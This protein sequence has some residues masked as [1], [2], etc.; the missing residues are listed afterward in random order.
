MLFAFCSW[1]LTAHLMSSTSEHKIESGEE[2][3]LTTDESPVTVTVCSYYFVE[4][5]F[6]IDKTKL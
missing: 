1:I 3:R 4:T 5:S 6:I 2:F